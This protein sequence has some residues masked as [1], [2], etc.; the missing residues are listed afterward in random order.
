MRFLCIKRQAQLSVQVLQTGVFLDLS[1]ACGKS[2]SKWLPAK[3][4]AQGLS[5]WEQGHLTA[6]D[7]CCRSSRTVS[8]Q[9]GRRCTSC[10]PT[11]TSLTV[12]WWKK[13]AAQWAANWWKT[14]PT[15]CKIAAWGSTASPSASWSGS[16]VRTGAPP[17]THQPRPSHHSRAPHQSIGRRFIAQPSYM[18]PLSGSG[19][20]SKREKRREFLGTDTV[21]STPQ[22]GSFNC[23]VLLKCNVWVHP[24]FRA[25]CSTFEGGAFFQ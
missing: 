2:A 25:Y 13:H 9:V 23:S 18:V 16:G 21:H 24:Q 10:L 7:G 6:G 4:L 15:P 17:V 3:G 1:L 11:A 5:R 8:R 12:G 22:P 19:E 20:A 14:V